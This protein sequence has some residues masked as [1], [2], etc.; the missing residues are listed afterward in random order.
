MCVCMCVS[1]CMRASACE[2]ERERKRKSK[3]KFV[4]EKSW[5]GG[6]HDSSMSIFNK[7]PLL[8]VTLAR[9]PTLSLTHTQPHARTPTL[10]LTRIHTQTH[11]YTHTRFFILSLFSNTL[12]TFT[13]VRSKKLVQGELKMEN[14]SQSK[15]LV[16]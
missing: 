10:S 11:P 15:M 13:S 2:G 1:E 6:L 3:R 14:F 5:V 16:P 8:S 4:V 7:L 12:G 9:T